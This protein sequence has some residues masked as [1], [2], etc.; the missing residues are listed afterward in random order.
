MT[1]PAGRG[2][3]LLLAGAARSGTTTLAAWIGRR[4]EIVSPSIKEP[5]FFSTRLERGQAW[6]ESLFDRPDGWWI[7]AS[8][9]YSYPSHREA[10]MRAAELSPDLRIVYLVRDPLPRAYSHYCHEVLYMG[11]HGAADFGSALRA[12]ADILGASDYGPV[13][14]GL[15]EAVPDDRV[16][17]LPFELVIG[18]PE[19]AARTVWDFMGLPPVEADDLAEVD[20]ELFRNE[21]AVFSNRLARRA[22]KAVRT[23]RLYPRIRSALGAE[24]MRR[25]RS[26]LTSEEAIPSLDTA[27]STC[28]PQQRADIAAV[29]GRSAEAVGAWLERQDA[30][31]GTNL[32]AECAWLHQPTLP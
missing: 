14:A 12:S 2:P 27:L 8:A 5:N 13:L 10:A 15:T 16:L 21:R 28:S 9:Q 7:D 3:D 29:A 19:R 22:F 18:D 17:V 23:T 24:R 25:M 6:Y 31:L 32:R 30:R 4:A 26:R 11:K 20:A 1:T